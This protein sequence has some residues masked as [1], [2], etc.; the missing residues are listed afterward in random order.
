MAT[1]RLRGDWLGG[2]TAYQLRDQVYVPGVGSAV[3][4]VPHESG[5]TFDEDF[6]ISRWQMVSADGA[7][8]ENASGAKVLLSLHRPGGITPRAC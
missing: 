2:G 6:A 4:L 5:D 1:S 7:A 3:A 8:G